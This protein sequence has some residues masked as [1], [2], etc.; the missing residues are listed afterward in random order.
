MI[1]SGN[2]GDNFGVI[3]K[4]FSPPLEMERSARDL[5]FKANGGFSKTVPRNLKK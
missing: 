5:A 3:M 4:T 1:T 2:V